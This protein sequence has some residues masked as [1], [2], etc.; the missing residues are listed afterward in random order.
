[1]AQPLPEKKGE[2]AHP[3]KKE[4]ETVVLEEEDA[5]EEFAAHGEWRLPRL[6][7]VGIGTYKID[8]QAAAK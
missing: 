8:I 7:M 3:P 6:L 5:F 1:M 4:S 2:E